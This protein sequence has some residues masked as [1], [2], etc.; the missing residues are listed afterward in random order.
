MLFLY[1]KR[2]SI[3]VPLLESEEETLIPIDRR[4]YDFS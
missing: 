3:S 4:R 2:I 1:Q